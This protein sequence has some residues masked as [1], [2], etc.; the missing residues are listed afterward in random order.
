M[1]DINNTYKVLLL[2]DCSSGK[3]SMIY[4]LTY[5]NFLEQYISTI[6][7]DFNVKSFI[8]NDKKIKLQIWDSCGQERF[9]ALTRSYYRN[10]DAFIVCYDISSNKSF[11]NAHFWLKELDKY[12]DRPVIKILVGTKNDLEDLR[13]VKYQDG[14]NFADSL[15]IDFMETSAKN[16]SNIR[17]LFYNLSVQLFDSSEE[18][19]DEQRHERYKSFSRYGTTTYG[20]C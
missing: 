14:K 17:D 20:C 18:K 7:I 9:N 3:T 16:N 1:Y 2:G 19:K 13:K 8:V 6:G 15:K 12:V 10:T 11:E 5:N 4:R